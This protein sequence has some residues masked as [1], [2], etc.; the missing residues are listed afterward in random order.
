MA[1]PSTAQDSLYLP[2]PETASID[3]EAVLEAIP[4]PAAIVGL[5][6]AVLHRNAAMDALCDREAEEVGDRS[7]ESVLGEVA[8]RRLLEEE[9]A[10]RV[11]A[12]DP[13]SPK[14]ER[15]WHARPCGTHS[16]ARLLTTTVA[17]GGTDHEAY[18]VEHQWFETAAALSGGLAHDFNN[19]LAAILGLS[20]IIALRLPDGSPLHPFATKI[21]GSVDRAKHLVRR[22]SH[23][24]RKR[25]G[26]VEPV[27]T[28]MLLEELVPLL[29]AFLPGNIAFTRSICADTPWCDFDRQALEQIIINCVSFLRTALRESGGSL[30]LAGRGTEDRSGVRIEITARGAGLAAVR[31]GAGLFE[32]RLD[33]TPSAYESGAGLFVARKLAGLAGGSLTAVRT[34]PHT[35]AFVATFPLAH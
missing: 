11:V 20:E 30:S 25:T 26:V 6:G 28:A 24:S 13:R 33:P 7:L 9:G 34:E 1:Q 32:L 14:L 3:L 18:I 10:C 5:D 19:A 31:E 21:A 17:P 8:L 4:G 29:A 12:A 22:F 15:T 35:L 27:P 16:G 2:S 23:F